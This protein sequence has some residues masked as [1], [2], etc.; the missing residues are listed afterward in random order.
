M[1][2]WVPN[3]EDV[4]VVGFARVEPSMTDDLSFGA[5][6][7]SPYPVIH[8]GAQRIE[9]RVDGQLGRRRA[10]RSWA[11]AAVHPAPVAFDRPGS[12]ATLNSQTNTTTCWDD[13]PRP[14]KRLDER[15]RNELHEH[16]IAAGIAF[17]LT[18]KGVRHIDASESADAR[19]P[20]GGTGGEKACVYLVSAHWLPQSLVMA[21]RA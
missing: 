9:L 19:G 1:G 8:R 18:N 14:A 15:R 3:D 2:A 6:V 20:Q 4:D 12:P 10:R 13:A 11:Q 7:Q 5:G 17:V 21:R 16:R